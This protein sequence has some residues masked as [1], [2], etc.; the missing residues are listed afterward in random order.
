[1][2]TFVISL[3]A[4]YLNEGLIFT[5]LILLDIYRQG[6]S[7]DVLKLSRM[8]TVAIL[9]VLRWQNMV[10][11]QVFGVRGRARLGRECHQMAVLNPD[12]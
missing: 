9:H 2:T 1:M 5:N 12:P 4:E 11:L 3:E 6:I 7:Y 10:L 8:A